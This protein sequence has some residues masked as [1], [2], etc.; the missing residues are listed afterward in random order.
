VSDGEAVVGEGVGD[1]VGIC[2]GAGVTSSV[3]AQEGSDVGSNDGSGVGPS[4]GRVDGNSDGRSDGSCDGLCVGSIDGSG[5]GDCA[6][7]GL[8]SADGRTL[9][10]CC[11]SCGQL[12]PPSEG[13]VKIARERMS[14]LLAAAS[15]A[16][17][18]SQLRHEV[19]TQSTGQAPTVHAEISCV[20][21]HAAPSSKTSRMRCRM[22]VSQDAEHPLHSCKATPTK[23]DVSRERK[24]KG[25]H[26]PHGH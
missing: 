16:A 18:A 17:Q 4:V 6:I 1:S 20:S 24:P 7:W 25:T 10:L 12:D 15:Q 13:A 11:E 8:T 2:E 26:L 21:V 22:P 5:V 9:A 23:A 3:G 14:P 19:T